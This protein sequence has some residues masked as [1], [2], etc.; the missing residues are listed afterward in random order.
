MTDRDD[1]TRMAQEAG[2]RFSDEEGPLIANHAEWQRQL[3][4]RFAAL[5]A[6]AE[7]EACAKLAASKASV[8]D[9]SNYPTYIAAAI[10]AR[11]NK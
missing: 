1:I 4:E 3:F 9:A 2:F 5:I 6:A 7:R 11:G 10:R 8:G